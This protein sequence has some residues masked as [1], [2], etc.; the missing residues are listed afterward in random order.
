MNQNICTVCKREFDVIRSI[1]TPSGPQLICEGC[2]YDEL[3]A[4]YAFIPLGNEQNVS[5]ALLRNE[6]ERLRESLDAQEKK[7]LEFL[8]IYE[9][10]LT[11]AINA[12]AKTVKTKKGDSK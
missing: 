6:C 8:D 3:E 12:G 9:T 7:H 2:A 4:T 1:Q 5:I 11:Q 10:Q